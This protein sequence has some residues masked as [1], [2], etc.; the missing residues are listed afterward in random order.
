MV[1]T[2]PTKKI[3]RCAVY[4]R[5]SSEEGLEQDFNSLEAQREACENYVRSQAH[6]GWTLIPDHF[7]DGGFSGGNMDRPALTRLMDLVRTGAVDVIVIYKIDRLTRSLMDFAKLAE[8]FE[9]NG[10][11]FV[12]VTQSFNTK[13][14]MGK[15]MLNVLLSFAQ[16]ERELTG[17]RIRDKLAA[18]KRRGM[19]VGGP[20]P[21][22]Y[23]VRDRQLIVSPTEAETVRKIFDLY[24]ELGNVRLVEEEMRRL[25]LRTKS[26]VS[27]AGRQMGDLSFT[28]GHLYKILSNPLYV[29][30]ISHKGERHKGLHDAIVDKVIWDRVQA[31][32]TDNTQGKRQRANAKEPSLLAGLLIDEFG[33]K[34]TATHAV[35]GGKRY[36]YYASKKSTARG[37]DY[38]PVGD[39]RVPAKEI[40]DAVVR[41]LT[42]FLRD[43]PRL[44]DALEL[45]A[46]TPSVVEV[47]CTRA[48]G[49][50]SNLTPALP[51]TQHQVIGQIV[52]CVELGDDEIRIVL[53]RDALL[54]LE[55]ESEQTT[56]IAISVSAQVTR[57]GMANRIV[58]EGANGEPTPNEPLIRAIACGRA[59]FEELASGRASSFGEIAARIGVTDR[60]VSRIVDLAFLAPDVVETILQGEQAVD[61]T[62][63][64][65]TV[66]GSVPVLW[67]EQ[68]RA[69][70]LD[71]R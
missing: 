49:F 64:S 13:D 66:D 68:R 25:D 15:L 38:Q 58:V 30:D 22:G 4:T 55:D 20:Q 6:E 1:E 42:M 56:P 17:E 33:H 45:R 37:A 54:G 53:K 12:S 40:E 35:K 51:G 46:A 61:L 7:D 57:H 44:I 41:E 8:E 60:Y 71:A 29:G 21:I 11:S 31:M 34:L 48:E 2:K 63:K 39:Y 47:I 59:W 69:L 50:A 5:K 32:L 36:R 23:D 26:Y 65:L 70:G 14:A 9:K 43:G 18:S 62:V 16:F 52:E 3:L 28:R 10:V 24:L 67:A 27:A 19:W